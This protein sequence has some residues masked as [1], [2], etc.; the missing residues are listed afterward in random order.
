MVTKPK[1][2][3]GTVTRERAPDYLKLLGL[4][5]APNREAADL[6]RQGIKSY[7]QEIGRRGGTIGGK[8]TSP[9]KQRSSRLNGRLGG[10]PRKDATKK[11]KGK[12]V[13]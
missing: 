2:V 12:A 7:L 1:P 11:S 8:S 6:W 3:S 4:K 5:A 13:E 10:R 9:A